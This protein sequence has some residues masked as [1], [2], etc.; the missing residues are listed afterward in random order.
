MWK[1][2]AVGMLAAVLLL[3]GCAKRRAV[4]DSEQ[5]AARLAEFLD[6]FAYSITDEYDCE[7]LETLTE[8]GKTVYRMEAFWESPEG[9][10]YS[11]GLFRVD[12]DGTVTLDRAAPTE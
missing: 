3:C 11:L 10:R 6:D 5:A 12:A 7:L 4:S 8:D 9:E 1:K 2:I